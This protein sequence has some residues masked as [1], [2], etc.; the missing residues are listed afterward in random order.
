MIEMKEDKCYMLDFVCL[1]NSNLR[2]YNT[3]DDIN[4]Y[5]Q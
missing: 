3:H 4:E 1:G 2:K 5:L